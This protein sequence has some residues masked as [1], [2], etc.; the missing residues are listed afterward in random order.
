M[1]IYYTLIDWLIFKVNVGKYIS[2]MDRMGFVGFE[3]GACTS[4]RTML[5]HGKWLN[6]VAFYKLQLLVDD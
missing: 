1:Y 6:H 4:L 5:Q 3:L 2:T